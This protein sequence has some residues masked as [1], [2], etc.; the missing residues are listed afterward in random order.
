MATYVLVHGAWHGAWC[1]SK[2]IPELETLGHRTITF[3]LPG[4]GDDPTPRRTVTLKSYAACIVKTLDMINE[5]V[6][7]MGHSMGGMAISVA[8]EQRPGKISTLVYLAAFLPKNGESLFTIEERSPRPS[9]PEN[10]V[11]AAN[12]KTGTLNPER[13]V[14]LFYHD[15]NEEDIAYAMSRLTPQPLE[16]LNTP[17]A[18][19]AER[20]GSIP[21]VYIECTDDHAISVELQR[22]MVV[23]SP[24]TKIISMNSSHSPFFSKPRELARILHECTG[25]EG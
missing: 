1:W 23:A 17:V 9:V 11:P 20:F 7:L 14:D 5:K 10:L 3:D 6:I 25:N 8:A 19:T 2:V 24:V 12:G 13:I 15:C 16:L 18:I 21:R 4:H 22:D